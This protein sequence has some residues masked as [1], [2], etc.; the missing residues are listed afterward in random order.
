MVGEHPDKTF[1]IGDHVVVLAD[2]SDPFWIALVTEVQA[3]ELTLQYYHHSK[4]SK[5]KMVWKIHEST[6]TIGILDVL[7]RF[8]IKKD[9]FT[10]RGII[11]KPAHKKISQACMTYAKIVISPSFQ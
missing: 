2:D 1:E 7:V 11:C 10:K 6:G 8:P 4:P 3:T 5:Q 9:L